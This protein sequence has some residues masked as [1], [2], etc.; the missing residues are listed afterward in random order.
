MIHQIAVGTW[1]Y[2]SSVNKGPDICWQLVLCPSARQLAPARE[3][4]CKKWAQ[5]EH[6]LCSFRSQ[7]LVLQTHAS[8]IPV[9]FKGSSAQVKAVCDQALVCFLFARLW[10]SRCLSDCHRVCYY[11]FHTSFFSLSVS[12]LMVKWSSSLPS[13]FFF[14]FGATV[15]SPVKSLSLVPEG[16][17]EPYFNSSLFQRTYQCLFDSPDHNFLIQVILLRTVSAQSSGISCRCSKGSK[18]FQPASS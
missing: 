11:P 16:N 3:K 15:F 13:F 4:Q 2:D 1:T 14:F 6:F 9:I 12:S 5:E 18:E 10:C 17:A 7:G 8:W